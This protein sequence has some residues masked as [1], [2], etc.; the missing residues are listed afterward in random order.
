MKNLVRSW[1]SVTSEGFV[2]VASE[3]NVFDG[4]DVQCNETWVFV[5][6]DPNV[7][8]ACLTFFP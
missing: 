4:S 6:L 2:V 8:E 7:F 3:N 5:V 1:I